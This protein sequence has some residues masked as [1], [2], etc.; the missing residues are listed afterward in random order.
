MNENVK[1]AV[2]AWG[3]GFITASTFGAVVPV[4]PHIGIPRGT[5]F[6]SCS[7]VQNIGAMEKTL[8]KAVR[9][10]GLRLPIENDANER[11]QLVMERVLAVKKRL[12]VVENLENHV[13]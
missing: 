9:K 12:K 4:P 10:S 13:V 6:M 2:L 5:P 3:S 11:R 7:V 8:K 1:N